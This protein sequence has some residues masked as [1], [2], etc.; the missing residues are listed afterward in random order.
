MTLTNEISNFIKR[1]VV[2]P[3]PELTGLAL[4]VLHTWSWEHCQVT[5]Y[6]YINSPVKQSGKTRLLEVLE[7]LVRRP[8]RASSITSSALYRVI[9]EN[10][11][12]LLLDEVD[13]VYNGGNRNEDLRGTL[14]SGYKLGGVS[15]RT[16]G[17]EVVPFP[18][19]CPKIMA[20]IQNLMIP[21]TVAD[22]CIS[23]ELQRKSQKEKVEPFI[24]IKQKEEVDPLLDKIHK[25]VTKNADEIKN[26]PYTDPPKDMPDRKW[27]IGQPLLTL[28]NL[29]K[30]KDGEAKIT[31]LLKKE[32]A[33]NTLNAT[34]QLMTDIHVLFNDTEKIFS[35]EIAESVEMS[36]KQLSIKLSQ[37]GIEPKLIR[38][39]SDVSRGYTKKDM[40][41]ILDRIIQ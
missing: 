41:P 13:V 21:D 24:Y 14:N 1:F 8:M 6:I 26:S 11:P 32:I 9:K 2:I 15:W 39:G 35:R 33:R 5:P 4:Y 16:A 34:E 7:L 17:G 40:R 12:V 27:E 19:F 28:A 30:V 37:F 3:E 36:P 29:A 20:G 23:I 18:T 25:W 10:D 22:R 38:I 31:E